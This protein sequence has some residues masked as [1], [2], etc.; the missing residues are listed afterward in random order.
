LRRARAGRLAFDPVDPDSVRVLFAVNHLGFLRNFESTLAML[1]ERGHRIHLV[2]DRSPAADTN[3]GRP[4]IDRLNHRYPGAF[5]WETLRPSK[6]DPWYGFAMGVRN[7]LNY[8]RYLSP[9]FADAPK[10]RARGRDQAPSPVVWLSDRPVVGSDTARGLMRPVLR[11]LEAL[12]PVR[13]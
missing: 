9:A 6:D 1:A 13:R 12:V 2:S 11:R 4:I 7:T 8:W 3:D 5:D 10:L